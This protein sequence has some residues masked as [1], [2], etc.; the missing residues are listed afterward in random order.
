MFL[1]VSHA[2]EAV[3]MIPPPPDV[4]GEMPAVVFE[5]FIPG[6]PL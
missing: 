2:L 5:K 4:A 6:A 1:V 3:F